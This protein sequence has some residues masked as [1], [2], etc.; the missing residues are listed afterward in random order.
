MSG[1][2]SGSIIYAPET[3]E[4]RVPESTVTYATVVV[5]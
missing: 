5:S 3:S 1:G 4:K 2:E